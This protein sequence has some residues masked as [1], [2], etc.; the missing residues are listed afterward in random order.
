VKR[1]DVSQKPT[2]EPKQ[3]KG[4]AKYFAAVGYAMSTLPASTL[5]Y[6]VVGVG[7]GGESC[8]LGLNAL[9]CPFYAVADLQKPF[10]GFH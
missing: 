1:C 6:T 9:L 4:V 10:T 5:C 3:N 2:G 7:E 8:P